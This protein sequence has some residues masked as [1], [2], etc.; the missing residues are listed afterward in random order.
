[1]AEL[2]LT[3]KVPALSFIPET[4]TDTHIRKGYAVMSAW[5]HLPFMRRGLVRMR[6]MMLSAG[7]SVE[8]DNLQ[9]DSDYPPITFNTQLE[10]NR[11]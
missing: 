9:V 5:N 7:I 4:K 11:I 8:Y 10:Q 1:L 3:Y 2:I 6:A